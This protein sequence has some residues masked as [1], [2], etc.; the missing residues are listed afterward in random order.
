[1]NPFPWLDMI[2]SNE[3]LKIDLF[4]DYEVFRGFFVLLGWIE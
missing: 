1:M 4:V 3:R 2:G